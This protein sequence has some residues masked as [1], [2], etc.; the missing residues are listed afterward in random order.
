MSTDQTNHNDETTG[1]ERGGYGRRMRASDADRAATAERL[2]QHYTEG[3]LDAQ[4]YDERIDRCYAAKTVGELDELFV[5][6]PRSAP[7]EPEPERGYGGY[8][9]YRGGL[10]PWRFAAIAAVIAALIVVSC[11]TGAHLFWLAWPLFFIFIFGPFGP[12]RRMGCGRP[13][14]RGTTAV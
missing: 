13:R 3:R 8:R 9:G 2:R 11:V 7:R 12:W 4:E 1:R 5:D 6:L 14:D 10:P